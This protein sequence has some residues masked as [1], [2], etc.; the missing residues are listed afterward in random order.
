MAHLKVTILKAVKAIYTPEELFL[1]I[2][3]S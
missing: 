1:Y 3:N 2:T